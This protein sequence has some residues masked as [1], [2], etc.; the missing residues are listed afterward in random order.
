[1]SGRRASKEAEKERE[2]ENGK[3]KREVE[4]ERAHESSVRT[5]IVKIGLK[6]ERPELAY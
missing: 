1:M 5:L 2:E 6:S 3:R 4:L